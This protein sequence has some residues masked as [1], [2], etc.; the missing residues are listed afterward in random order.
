MTEFAAEQPEGV[1]PL[2]MRAWAAEERR[3]ADEFAAFLEDV[4]TSGLPASK[5]GTWE[6]LRERRLAELDEESGRAHVA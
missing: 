1:D 2:V 5:G 6:E 4:A 3:R